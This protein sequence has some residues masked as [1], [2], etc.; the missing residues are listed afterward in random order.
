MEGEDQKTLFLHCKIFASF[1]WLK[2]SFA[3]RQK[4]GG[5]SRNIWVNSSSYSEVFT[6]FYLHQLY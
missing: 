5:S 2:T 6:S 4:I 3:S 1:T